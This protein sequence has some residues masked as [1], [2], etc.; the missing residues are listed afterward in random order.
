MKR[1]LR[2]L[3]LARGFGYLGSSLFMYSTVKYQLSKP[4]KLLGGKKV[5]EPYILCNN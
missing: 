5:N 2:I 3:G 4:V 1:V